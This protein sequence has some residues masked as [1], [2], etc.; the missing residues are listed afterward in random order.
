MEI[1]Q[2]QVVNLLARE[3]PFMGLDEEQLKEVAARFQPMY[4][5]K[6][7][8]IYR[9]GKPAKNF[10][11]V[12]QGKVSVSRLVKK[13]DRELYVLASGDFFGDAGLLSG[14]SRNETVKVIEDATLL[15][16]SK[17]DFQKLLKD[18][19]KTKTILQETARSRALAVK[20]DFSWLK[21]RETVFLISR[22]HI[23]FMLLSLFFPSLLGLL[24][25]L[26][27]AAPILQLGDSWSWLMFV[28]GMFGL[29]AALLWGWWNW[30]NWENDYFVVTNWRVLW[31]EKVIAFYE[32]R[33]E[34]RL[35]KT[36]S[37]NITRP[38]WGRILDYGTIQ[39]NTFTGKISM[40]RVDRPALIAAYVDGLKERA[41]V[42][43]L[44]EDKQAIEDEL[45]QAYQLHQ[46]PQEQEVHLVKGP[47][48][49]KSKKPGYLTG[50]LRT[51]LRLRYEYEGVITY[52]KH[53]FVLIRKNILPLVLLLVLAALV[54]GLGLEGSL[55]NVALGGGLCISS[56]F[57]VVIG[58]MT[59]NYLDWA[60]DL[61]QLSPEYIN[62]LERKPLGEEIVN[63]AKLE[64]ILSIE[65]ERGN[66]VRII[67]D[68]GTVAINVGD[69]QFTFNDVKN[70]GRVHQDIAN[71]QEAL[72]QRKREADGRRQRQQLAQW[73]ITNSDIE[74]EFENPE[75]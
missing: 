63:S 44:E 27:M 49:K 14:S 33:R 10:Y 18:Y 54:V 74:S 41:K 47:A 1:Y 57:L 19:P 60:N 16:M 61:Y 75:S 15:W 43:T 52:R 36:Q 65:H 45:K 13:Q 62:E 34:A 56:L 8:V 11:I 53:W 24:S 39:V 42:V 9:Q 71:Y 72:N 29:F 5:R 73:F 26:A 4:R 25:F 22:K 58:W 40:S 55:D 46:N 3:Y 6:D 51:F 64:N 28:G 30:A 17:V 21:D 50:A 31:L 68:F 2:V 7:K 59:Y 48:K 37:N 69:R 35:D 66:L 38:F 67:L 12:Y 23:I 20:R 70:P 32:S